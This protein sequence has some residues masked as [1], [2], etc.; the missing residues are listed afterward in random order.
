[1]GIVNNYSETS[2]TTRTLL[3]NFESFSQIL[4]NNQAK[5]RTYNLTYPIAIIE[6]IWKGGW[7]PKAKIRDFRTVNPNIF[8]K[9]SL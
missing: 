7:L 8:T 4:K 9:T 6:K 2:M 1:M 5:K 3:E